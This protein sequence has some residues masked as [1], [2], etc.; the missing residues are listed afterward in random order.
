MIEWE[1]MIFFLKECEGMELK[2]MG[3]LDLPTKKTGLGREKKN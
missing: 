1:G 3:T 2:G